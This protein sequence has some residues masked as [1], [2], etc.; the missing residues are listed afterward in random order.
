MDRNPV[1]L[2]GGGGVG[3]YCLVLHGGVVDWYPVV[4]HGG[5]CDGGRY[6]LVLHGGGRFRLVLGLGVVSRYLVILDVVGGL[7]LGITFV[8]VTFG[9]YV[10][11]LHS[12]VLRV[13]VRCVLLGEY[14]RPYSD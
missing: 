1:V 5:G 2:H 4:L 7:Y 12:V 11:V 13:L 6:C 10:V 14:L 9:L 3:W 8:R